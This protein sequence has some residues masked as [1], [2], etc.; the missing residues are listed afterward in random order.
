MRVRVSFSFQMGNIFTRST[1]Q[2]ALKGVI[3]GLTP[4]F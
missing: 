3:K 1:F 4:S 2:N